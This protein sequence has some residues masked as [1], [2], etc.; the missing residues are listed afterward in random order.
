MLNPSKFIVFCW[1]LLFVACKLNE[2]A[3]VVN[4]SSENE[5]S[6]VK[7]GDG[8][9]ILESVVAELANTYALGL[10]DIRLGAWLS[11]Y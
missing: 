7:Y 4:S 9:K 8:T 10:A 2:E 1:A 5:G 11:R 3:S 6:I